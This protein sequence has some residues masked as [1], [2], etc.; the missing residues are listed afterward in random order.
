MRRLVVLGYFPALCVALV[1]GALIIAV[2]DAAIVANE[3]LERWA[4]VAPLRRP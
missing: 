3:R 2:V 1:L 4:G